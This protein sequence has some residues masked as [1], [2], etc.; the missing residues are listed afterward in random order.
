MIFLRR[1]P[2]RLLFRS[3]CTSRFRL[4][5]AQ[6]STSTPLTKDQKCALELVADLTTSALAELKQKVL[7]RG[8]SQQYLALNKLKRAHSVEQVS[9]LGEKLAKHSTEYFS[10][11]ENAAQGLQNL[12][13]AD[14][15]SPSI[16]TATPLIYLALLGRYPDLL[17]AQRGLSTKSEIVCSILTHLLQEDVTQEEFDAATRPLPAANWDITQPAEWFPEARKMK[18]KVIMH[19]GPTNSGKT[20]KA[21]QRLAE[22]KSGYYA[23]PLRLLARE[24]Y[25]RFQKEDVG[26]NLITGEEVVPCLDKFG[27]VAGLSS[28]TIEM[29]PLHKQMDV[30]IID[31]IQMIEDPQRGAAWTNAVLGVQA[32]ELHLCGEE[33][34]VNLLQDMLRGSGHEVSV[35]RYERLGKLSML[36]D[37]VDSLAKIQKGDCVVAFSKKKIL[38]LKGQIER[39]TNYK[40]GVIY[41][42]LPP[43]IRSSESSLFNL[44][45]YDVLVASDAIGMG[46]NL[47]I[48][49]VVFSGVKKFNGSEMVNLPVTNIKQIAGRAGRFSATEGKQDGYV[50]AFNFE[51][52]KYVKRRLFKKANDIKKAALWP[53]NEFW[54]DYVTGFDK[55]I[56]LA[57]AFSLFKNDPKRW[58]SPSYFLSEFSPQ[59]LILELLMKRGLH[60]GITIE[61]QLKLAQV[62]L[63]LEMV[64]PEVLETAVQF[65]QCIRDSE[66]KTIFDFGFLQN[67]VI[68][69]EPLVG[70]LESQVLAALQLL[71]SNH[72]LVLVFMWLAQRWPTLFIDT[73]S[74]FEMKTLIEKRISEELICL[75]AVSGKSQK[76]GGKGKSKSGKG[77]SDYKRR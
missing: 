21:L 66:S 67:S 4:T 64:L 24:V 53:P 13:F 50:S 20:Y 34:A 35:K 52:W 47:K 14:F 62:P 61:D 77:R 48:K 63:N 70:N 37:S 75:R 32:K 19:V 76:S 58:E 27:N 11:E 22:A 60:H 10:N 17:A 49:R 43:E 18:R 57:T 30:C 44:G 59:L 1:P 40:V 56:S 8:F 31:E 69:L 41:G 3:F 16:R 38:E 73:E 5:P 2:Q 65:F 45:H 72:K 28:G 71:E 29:I 33:R 51:N 23:G 15:F 54:L 26:C 46:L 68:S 42:A 74:A 7:N 6:S 25:E 36:P 12:T 39:A 9:A 55:P